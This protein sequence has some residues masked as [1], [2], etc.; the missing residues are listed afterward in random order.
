M[1]QDAV[2]RA[3]YTVDPDD[4]ERMLL[5]KEQLPPG[6]EG[7]RVVREGELSNEAMADLP[8]AGHTATDLR[9]LGRVTGFQREWLTT[10]PEENLGDGADLALATVVHFMESPEA[11]S[12]WM[13]SVFLGEFKEKVGQEMG[14]GHHLLSVQDL[15]L[16]TSFHHEAVGLRAV[17]EGPKGLVSSSV[18]DFRVG[19][20]LGVV[21]VV[22]VGDKDRLGVAETLGKTLERH[23]ISVVLGAA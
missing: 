11:V 13:E 18:L 15:A 19:R 8:L 22:T 2:T 3:T 14:Q 23:M 17:Q 21:Y 10:V 16:G 5:S 20:L 7:F 12:N 9:R 1:E 6:T 4:L